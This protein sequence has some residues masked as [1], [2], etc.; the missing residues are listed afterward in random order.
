MNN[1][2]LLLRNQLANPFIIVSLVMVMISILLAC[3][4]DHEYPGPLEMVGE[5][6]Q[7]VSS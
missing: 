2:F 4:K 3:K 7:F 6:K 5:I 1:Y